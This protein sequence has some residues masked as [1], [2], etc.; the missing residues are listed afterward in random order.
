MRSSVLFA[1]LECPGPGRLGGT[2]AAVGELARG[3]R[4]PHLSALRAAPDG[5]GKDE[6]SVLVLDLVAPLGR[7]KK[8]ARGNVS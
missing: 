1:A 5:E 6:K 2:C 7:E 3:R 4:C 8:E